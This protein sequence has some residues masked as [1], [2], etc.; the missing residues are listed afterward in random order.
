M[1]YRLDKNK[2]FAEV[3]GFDSKYKYCQDGKLFLGDGRECDINGVPVEKDLDKTGVLTAAA[4]SNSKIKMPGRIAKP[5][6]DE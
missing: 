5:K 1:T 4:E 6:K 3:I 2:P